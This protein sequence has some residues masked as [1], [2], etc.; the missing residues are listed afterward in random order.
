M[1]RTL[2]AP[3]MDLG[4]FWGSSLSD[5]H[6]SH[7][8]YDLFLPTWSGEHHLLTVAGERRGLWNVKMTTDGRRCNTERGVVTAHGKTAHAYCHPFCVKAGSS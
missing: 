3:L 2:D 4:P 5:T 8:M 7:W 1:P 6:M